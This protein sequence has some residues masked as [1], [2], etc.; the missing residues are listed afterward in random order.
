ML[1]V[2]D[3]VLQL[4]VG[5][6]PGVLH[7]GHQGCALGVDGSVSQR[8]QDGGGEHGI[9]CRGEL[10]QTVGELVHAAV[11]L[12]KGA[13]CQFASGNTV[14]GSN[15]WHMQVAEKGKP[16]HRRDTCVQSQRG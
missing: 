4:P 5:V 8:R 13:L 6:T 11:M 9:Y 14:S 16:T 10:A 1:V 15:E 12:V 3:L 7:F 2:A